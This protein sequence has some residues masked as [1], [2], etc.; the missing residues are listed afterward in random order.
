MIL[1][2]V[3]ARD[4]QVRTS[5][6]LAGKSC[7][8]FAPCGPALVTADEID[9][10]DAL[11]IRTRVNGALVQDD[12]VGNM[13]FSVADLV[14]EISMLMTLEVGDIIATGT[15]SGVG[16]SFD[17]PRFLQPGDEVAVEIAGIGELSNTV[18]ADDGAY[19]EVER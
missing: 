1:N 7:D 17:P 10:V 2:D 5:Q 11:R 13:T 19:P 8:T 18:V 16:M 4:L 6:W 9:D 14:A 3:S 12:R 15:P